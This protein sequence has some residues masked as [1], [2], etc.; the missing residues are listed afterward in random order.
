[1]YKLQASTGVSTRHAWA[2]ALQE[3][4]SSKESPWACGPPKMMET[5][6]WRGLSAGMFST[7]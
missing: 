2:R 4:A 3:T 1:M 6:S 5:R 7:A